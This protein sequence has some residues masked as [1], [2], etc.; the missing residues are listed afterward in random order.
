MHRK[1]ISYYNKFDLGAIKNKEST[2]YVLKY[3]F[4]D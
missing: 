4:Y 2:A 3:F 1:T